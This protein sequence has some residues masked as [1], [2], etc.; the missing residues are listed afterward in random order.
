MLLNLDLN[1]NKIR[2]QIQIEK[3]YLLYITLFQFFFDLVSIEDFIVAGFCNFL[4]E[5]FFVICLN[6]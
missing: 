4:S 5:F 3:K 2:R 6:F 1:F